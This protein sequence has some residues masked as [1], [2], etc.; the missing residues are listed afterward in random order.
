MNGGAVPI[1]YEATDCVAVITIDRPE[2]GNSLDHSALTRELPDAWRRAEAD[3]AVIAVVLTASGERNFCS[4]VDI[5][6][7]A[8]I[9]I[10]TGDAEPLPVR[11]TSR[12]QAVGKPV[13]VAVN[14]HCTGGG[15]MLVADGDIVL[16]SQNASF[17]NPGVSIGI[18]ATMGAVVL[19][20]T[21]DFKRV[22][23]MT[24]AGRAEVLD[25]PSAL[26]AGL[27]SEVVAPESLL[28]RA[29]EV[30][31][32]LAANSPAAMREAKRAIW[33]ALELPLG[34]ALVEAEAGATHFR[35]HPDAA[36]GIAALH[37]RRRPVWAPYSKP[38][39]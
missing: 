37:E 19:G 32:S 18:A 23:R 29:L 12:D 17:D 1:T 34:D 25:A 35:T 10:T 3:D 33:A 24:L 4:G 31:R 11:I 16:A 7:P 5:R 27:V 26:A 15:L 13:I 39:G 21:A 6:D 28:H 36:E 14:G 38:D 22:L 8:I 30:A 20:R 2:R 9:A